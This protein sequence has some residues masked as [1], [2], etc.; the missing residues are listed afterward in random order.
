[1]RSRHLHLLQQAMEELPEIDPEL[2]ISHNIAISDPIPTRIQVGP[3]QI[4]QNVDCFEAFTCSSIGNGG[5]TRNR[6]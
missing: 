2:A 1:M 6:P 4:T 5:I 3:V